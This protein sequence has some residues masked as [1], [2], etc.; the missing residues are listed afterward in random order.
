MKSIDPALDILILIANMLLNC[1]TEELQ[2]VANS[3]CIKCLYLGYA[4]HP[5]EL[6]KKKKY[7]EII[8]K[9]VAT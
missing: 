3:E 8:I 2:S 5:M 1:N 9:I 6:E 4:L 7:L